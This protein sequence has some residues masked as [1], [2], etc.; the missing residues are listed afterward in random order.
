MKA[1]QRIFSSKAE[2][3]RFVFSPLMGNINYTFGSCDPLGG[4]INHLLFG[5]NHS[6]AALPT[7]RLP[8]YPSDRPE[9]LRTNSKV[10]DVTCS[11]Y[12]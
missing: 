8:A 2:M 3:C 4:E 6:D 7:L 12:E 1:N 9:N 5:G 10:S 11:L